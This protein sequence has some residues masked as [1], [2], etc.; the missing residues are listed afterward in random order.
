K[1]DEAFRA[2]AAWQKSVDVAEAPEARLELLRVGLDGFVGA[3][4]ALEQVLEEFLVRRVALRLDDLVH[5]ALERLRGRAERLEPP[6]DEVLREHLP[7][8]EVV[9]LRD[10]GEAGVV[11]LRD[12]EF[13]H[14]EAPEAALSRR[15]EACPGAAAVSRTTASDGSPRRG[16]R[17]S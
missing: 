6:L 16:R 17:A 2:C 1:V 11:V 3:E 14:G 8:S 15:V 5:L 7:A 13:L 10:R 12:L 4:A 9:L